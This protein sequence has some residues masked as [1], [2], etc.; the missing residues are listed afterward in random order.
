M[1]S[2]ETKNSRIKESRN[3]KNKEFKNFNS[4]EELSISEVETEK[5]NICFDTNG[6]EI[7]TGEDINFTN[8]KVEEQFSFNTQSVPV[9]NVNLKDDDFIKLNIN[10]VEAVQESLTVKRSYTLRPSTVKML[11]ELKVF[12]YDDPYIKYN[13]IVDAAIRSFYE[14]KKKGM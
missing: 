11:Q 7:L 5:D 10:S 4:I 2:K 1:G 8:A 12:I 9:L 6:I 14:F 13:D 3:F